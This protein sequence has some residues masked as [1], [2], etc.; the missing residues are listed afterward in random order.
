MRASGKLLTPNTARRI[1]RV[2]GSPQPLPA[3]NQSIERIG[4]RPDLKQ[5]IEFVASGLLGGSEPA[6]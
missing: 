4:N 2:T 1:L 3:R 5:A 6:I